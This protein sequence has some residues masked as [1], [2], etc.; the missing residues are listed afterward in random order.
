VS[1]RKGEVAMKSEQK[2]KACPKIIMFTVKK[3]KEGL[4]LSNQRICQKD[5]Q[6]H[7]KN[8]VI[9]KR[10]KEMLKKI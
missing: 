5:W 9:E 1:K 4:H 2:D 6:K 10:L 3:I 8:S 7:M